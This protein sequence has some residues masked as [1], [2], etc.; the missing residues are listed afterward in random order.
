[1][2]AAALLRELLQ[3]RQLAFIHPALDEARIHAVEAEHDELLLESLGSPAAAARERG[4][5]ANDQQ[6]EQRA[7][8]SVGR[9]ENYNIW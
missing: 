7:F 3:V 5:E 4:C 8:H 1:V 6:R 2:H 9:K